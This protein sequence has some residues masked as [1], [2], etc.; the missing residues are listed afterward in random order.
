[1]LSP[2]FYLLLGKPEHKV[3]RRVGYNICGRNDRGR[4]NDGNFV[5]KKDSCRNQSSGVDSSATRPIEQLR[6]DVPSCQRV[7]TRDA[8]RQGCDSRAAAPDIPSS[9][10]IGPWCQ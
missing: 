3:S 1:M 6:L 10:E 5:T 8:S 9:S 2:R 4:A 7:S